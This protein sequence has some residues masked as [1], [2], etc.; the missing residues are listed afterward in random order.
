MQQ[1][2]SKPRHLQIALARSWCNPEKKCLKHEVLHEEEWKIKT[3]MKSAP[4]KVWPCLRLSPFLRRHAGRRCWEANRAVTWTTRNHNLKS[5]QGFRA[6]K[7][8]NELRTSLRTIFL[9][10]MRSRSRERRTEPWFQTALISDC[11]ESSY[12]QRDL[13]VMGH[14]IQFSPATE[15]LTSHAWKSLVSTL[16]LQHR[17][18]KR[19]LSMFKRSLCQRPS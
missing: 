2:R 17:K 12:V 3:W 19:S 14:A 13:H 5:Q 16:V 7:K 15:L 18:H 10:L 11:K 6:V 4:Q 1:Q 8:K 9:S